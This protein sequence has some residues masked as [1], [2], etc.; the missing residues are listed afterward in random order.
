MCGGVIGSTFAYL[1]SI[2][3]YG[4][5]EHGDMVQVQ[6]LTAQFHDSCSHGTMTFSSRNGFRRRF[7]WMKRSSVLDTGAEMAGS[8]PVRRNWNKSVI[9]FELNIHIFVSIKKP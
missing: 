4:C 3:I 2:P 8:I 6:V 7:Q 1:G 5:W 9:S